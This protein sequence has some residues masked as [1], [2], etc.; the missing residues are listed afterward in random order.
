MEELDII[1]AAMLTAIIIK[2]IK[3]LT[4]HF[5]SSPAGTQSGFYYR[6]RKHLLLLL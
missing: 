3:K 1:I 6:E 5:H 4:A 2:I